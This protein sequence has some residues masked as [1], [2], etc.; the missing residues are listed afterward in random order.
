VLTID[1]FIGRL[2]EWEVRQGKKEAQIA[3]DLGIPLSTYRSFKA[4]GDRGPALVTLFRMM[5]AMGVETVWW[6]LTGETNSPDQDDQGALSPPPGHG[7]VRLPRG[8]SQPLSNT[9]ADLLEQALTV[10][11]GKGDAQTFATAL[12][13]NIKAFHKSVQMANIQQ[14]SEPG[15]GKLSAG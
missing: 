10:L 6:L 2:S 11:R 13:A 4:G 5:E 12:S 1:N 8:D 15:Q 7:M 14:T 3:R 9:E